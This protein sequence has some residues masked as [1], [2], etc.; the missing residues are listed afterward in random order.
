M[1]SF[2]NIQTMGSLFTQ[3]LFV[4]TTPMKGLRQEDV[5]GV[6]FLL[7]LVSLD[8]SILSLQLPSGRDLNKTGSLQVSSP[9]NMSIDSVL[10]RVLPEAELELKV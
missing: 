3:L 2:A 5:E 1:E 9:L 7:L 8:S 10:F 6:Y 4:G